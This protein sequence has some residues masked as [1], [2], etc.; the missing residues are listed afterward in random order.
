MCSGIQCYFSTKDGK[1]VPFED[2]SYKGKLSSELAGLSITDART[3]LVEHL[4]QLHIKSLEKGVLYANMKIAIFHR[5]TA[6]RMLSD[7]NRDKSNDDKLKKSIEELEF[8]IS[9]YEKE[10]SE[11][12]EE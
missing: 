4:P 10:L 5:R 12:V 11:L 9:T 1:I 7:I 6:A 8:Q 2:W 3:F